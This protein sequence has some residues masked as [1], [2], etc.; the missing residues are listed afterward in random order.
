M[1]NLLRR[2]FGRKATPTIFIPDISEFQPN[3]SEVLFVAGGY[4]ALIARV[5]YGTRLDRIMPARRDALRGT[6]PIIGWYIFLRSS[7]SLAS[8]LAT[9]YSVIPSLG[10][11]EFVVV[12]WEKD[13]DGT[14]PSVAMRNQCLAALQSHYGRAPWLY[15]PASLLR[16]NPAPAGDPEWVASYETSNPNLAGEVLWQYTDG[17]YTSAGIPPRNFPGIGKC[18]ASIFPGTYAQLEARLNPAPT[19]PIPVPPPP[20]PQ[21]TTSGDPIEMARDYIVHTDEPAAGATPANPGGQYMVSQDGKNT[22][23]VPLYVGSTGSAL[24]GAQ[25]ATDL[26]LPYIHMDPQTL[27]ALASGGVGPDQIH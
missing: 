27:K 20:I 10:P 22:I 6:V 25:T 5:C 1:L 17:I 14:T 8:Q 19:P 15:G 23:V 21:P 13:V 4:K 24:T 3:I 18:D 12:D 11:Y 16:N 2:I 9:F 26:G 7:Q